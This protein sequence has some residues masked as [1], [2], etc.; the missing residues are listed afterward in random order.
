MIIHCSL[1]IRILVYLFMM[2]YINSIN[3]AGYTLWVIFFCMIMPKPNF[4]QEWKL[5]KKKNE[6]WITHE[7]GE[8][9]LGER[10]LGG[11][12]KC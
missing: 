7:L 4:Y 12:K 5:K 8:R 2:V 3:K 1:V 9:E 6:N 11:I 10:E